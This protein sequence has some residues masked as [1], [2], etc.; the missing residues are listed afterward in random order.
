MM[1][2]YLR[3]LTDGRDLKLTI[4]METEKLEELLESHEYLICDNSLADS[5]LDIDD[6]TS[7][8]GLNEFLL[9]CKEESISDEVI[10]VIGKCTCGFEEI[11]ETI[12]CGEY[13]I[14]LPE[15][16]N[17]DVDMSSDSDKGLLLFSAGYMNL[18][19]SYTPEMEDYIRWDAVWN[20]ANCS[21]W[22]RVRLD[23][24]QDYL[25]HC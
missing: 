2:L 24:D 5:C 3:D 10:L 17:W 19:F 14:V 11:K 22:C 1:D 13:C 4:P 21:G 8:R 23:C 7:V 15:A 6:Y 18:P 20:D 25:V 12:E 16:V 9:Y